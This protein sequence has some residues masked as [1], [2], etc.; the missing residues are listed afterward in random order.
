M[1][2][3]M[4]DSFLPRPELSDENGQ[5]KVVLRNT[6]T[7]SDADKRFVSQFVAD[8]LTREE[9]R[10]LLEAYRAGQVDNARMRALTGL[11]TLQSSTLLRRLRDRGY[12]ELHSAGAASYYTLAINTLRDQVGMNTGELGMDTGELDSN[13]GEL[14]SN[15]GELAGNTGEHQPES[16]MELLERLPSSLQGL[17]QALGTRPRKSSFR[18]VLVAVASH[19]DWTPKQLATLFLRGNTR[20]L[21][22]EHITP[23]LQ[24]GMLER[25][26]PDVPTHPQQSYRATPKGLGPLFE[27]KEDE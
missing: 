6:A 23:L 27:G 17:V 26:I 15:T 16:R 20:K 18:R 25:T 8:D 1:F 9:F 7:L 10:A 13:T 22:D 5:F 19:G 24:D 12:L 2:H 21:V 4:Q 3:E 11:D 14:D